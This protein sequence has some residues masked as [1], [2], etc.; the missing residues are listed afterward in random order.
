MG[1]Q[2][3]QVGEWVDRDITFDAV[4]QFVV[5]MM[6][7]SQP[8]ASCFSV[9][10]QE[11]GHSAKSCCWIHLPSAAAILR[12]EVRMV[13]WDCVMVFPEQ[14]QIDSFI[15][16]SDA[17]NSDLDF[18]KNQTAF[19]HSPLGISVQTVSHRS[20]CFTGHLLVSMLYLP[21]YCLRPLC[22]KAALCSRLK[23]GN[24]LPVLSLF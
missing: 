10:Q 5:Y 4:K 20:V 8:A 11:L 23:L 17:F 2:I 14:L 18:W 9:Q 22:E 12:S 15:Y 6:S 7:F 16:W 3:S 13:F 1:L 19:M 24:F 21:M